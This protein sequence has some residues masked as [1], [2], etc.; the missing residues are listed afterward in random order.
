MAGALNSL[1]TG[2]QAGTQLWAR[3]AR[4]FAPLVEKRG[5]KGTARLTQIGGA[6]DHDV[7]IIANLVLKVGRR[8][9]NLTSAKVFGTCRGRPV[10]WPSRDGRVESTG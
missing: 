3:F 1:D 6:N 8:E 7:I 9:I 10:P 5:R 4:D 2:N